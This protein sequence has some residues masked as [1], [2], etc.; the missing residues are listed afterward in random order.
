[1][2]DEN[3][4]AYFFEP[5]GRWHDWFAWFPIRTYDNRLVWLERVRRRRLQKHWYLHG[6]P[7]QIWQYQKPSPRKR[8]AQ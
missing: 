7:D 8:K 6:G 4:A 1:M 2:S 5:I 3:P